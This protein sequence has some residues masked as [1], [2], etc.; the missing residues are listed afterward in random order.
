[1]KNKALQ[2]KIN[3]YASLASAM[4]T[5]TIVEGQ[6]IYYDFDPDIGSKVL[7]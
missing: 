2:K 4:V 7:V 6:V 5:P 1:M 3:S